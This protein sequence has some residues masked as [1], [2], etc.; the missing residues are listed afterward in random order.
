MMA[1][2][3]PFILFTL[4]VDS[5]AFQEGKPEVALAQ[6]LRR[7]AED[8]LNTASG[9]LWLTRPMDRVR[10]EL[11]D[12]NSE[13]VGFLRWAI[14]VRPS[15]P[16]PG[17]AAIAVEVNSPREVLALL[18]AIAHR[19]EEGREVGDVRRQGVILAHYGINSAPVPVPPPPR[20]R[21]DQLAALGITEDDASQFGIR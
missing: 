7:C 12:A 19:L 10:M 4:R 16:E 18:D 14:G 8:T 15:S 21:A 11:F 20:S 5:P 6:L 17:H 9:T 2:A 3:Q 13:P 1:S